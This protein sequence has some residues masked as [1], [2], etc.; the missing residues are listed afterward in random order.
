MVT[1]Y[2]RGYSAEADLF[3]RLVDI[4]FEGKRAFKSQGA[5][6][7]MMFTGGYRPLLIEVKYYSIMTAEPNSVINDKSIKRLLKKVNT[8]KLIDRARRVDAYPLFAFKIKGKGYLFYRL[9]NDTRKFIPYKKLKDLL[10]G[11]LKKK[12]FNL[13]QA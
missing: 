2:A 4:G 8:T 1:P 6:D 3:N 7:L 9:D 12:P 10:W 13:S 5:Y 11:F